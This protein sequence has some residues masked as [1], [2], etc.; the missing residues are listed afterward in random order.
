MRSNRRRFTDDQVREIRQSPLSARELAD[1]Y[2]V[3]HPTILNIRERR[4]YKNVPDHPGVNLLEPDLLRR[5][6]NGQYFLKDPLDFLM[7]VPGGYCGTAVTA[8]PVR[9]RPSIIGRSSGWTMDDERIAQREYVDLQREVIHECLRVVGPEG[10]L[11]YHHRHEVSTRRSMDTRHDVFSH[12]P[13]RQIII[14]NHRMRLFVPGRHANRVPNNYGVI[15][16]FS[17]PRW[18][19]P[20]RSRRNAMGWGDVWDIKPDPE[21]DLWDP[22]SRRR[23]RYAYSLPAELADRCI[24]FGDGAVLDPFAASGAVALAAIR[25]GRDWLACDTDPAYYDAFETRRAMMSW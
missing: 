13:L 18:S 4:T 25:A 15:Y 2:D 6:V 16:V 9:Q 24:A 7:S 21:E 19:I 17:G 10:V 12:F 3:S 11:L 20:E 5:E 22:A 23:P 14:W 1:Q 8:P